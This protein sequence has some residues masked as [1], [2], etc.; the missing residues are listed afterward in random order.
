MHLMGKGNPRIESEFRSVLATQVRNVLFAYSA[1][2][3]PPR[4][5]QSP[6][7]GLHLLRVIDELAEMGLFLS[8]AQ[9]TCQRIGFNCLH[10]LSMRIRVTMSR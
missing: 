1:S 3:D 2:R 5:G 10:V 6:S 9:V 8:K 4:R 7:D